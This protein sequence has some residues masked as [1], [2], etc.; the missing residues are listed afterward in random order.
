MR[1]VL[2]HDEQDAGNDQHYRL[3]KSPRLFIDRLNKHRAIIDVLGKHTAEETA[4]KSQ[5][6]VKPH[7]DGQFQEAEEVY[8]PLHGRAATTATT[9]AFGALLDPLRQVRPFVS[10]SLGHG[11]GPAGQ[12]ARNLSTPHDPLV[13]SGP[14]SQAFRG[15]G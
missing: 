7:H 5:S 3:R 8:E 13:G 11:G 14:S 2:T 4:A 10:C 9:T 15:V 6:Q 1:S 12:P